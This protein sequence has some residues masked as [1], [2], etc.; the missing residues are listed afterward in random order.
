MIAL[1]VVVVQ[2]FFKSHT[3]ADSDC[4]WLKQQAVNPEQRNSVRARR[5]GMSAAV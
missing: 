1:S 5:V 4:N 3:N 2:V